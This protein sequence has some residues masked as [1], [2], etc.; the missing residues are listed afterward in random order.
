MENTFDFGKGTLSTLEN[1]F[2]FGKGTLSTLER[3]A[4]DFGKV[5]FRLWK[6]TLS[7]LENSNLK[8]VMN[9]SNDVK[10]LKML[11]SVSYTHLTL[12]TILLV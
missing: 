8:D 12:P 9:H 4:F 6:G 2:D 10:A 3:Y 11:M 7:T 1:T 5:R